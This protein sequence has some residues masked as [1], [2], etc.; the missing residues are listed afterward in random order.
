MG[1]RKLRA[2]VEVEP[3]EGLPLDFAEV[4]LHAQLGI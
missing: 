3:V 2:S 4:S 1:N